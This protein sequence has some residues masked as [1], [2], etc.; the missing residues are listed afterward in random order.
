MLFCVCWG[1]KEKFL[2]VQLCTEGK[3]SKVNF[4]RE[5]CLRS[6]F[7]SFNIVAKNKFV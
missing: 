5:K 7:Y 1:N 2:R 6:A 3:F 4:Q